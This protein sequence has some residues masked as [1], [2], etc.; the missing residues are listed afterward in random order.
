MNYPEKSAT[1]C[2]LHNGYLLVLFG[3]NKVTKYFELLGKNVLSL[4]EVEG[5]C[6]G[7]CE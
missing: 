7:H 2:S 6:Q 5:P 4:K 3:I 1:L